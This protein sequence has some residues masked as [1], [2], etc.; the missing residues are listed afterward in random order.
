MF[1]PKSFDHLWFHVT[2]ATVCSVRYAM[3]NMIFQ[4]SMPFSES[5]TKG[6]H[7][8][9]LPYR[10]ESS[11]TCF[12]SK[13][14]PTRQ[15][16]LLVHFRL[17]LVSDPGRACLN[18]LNHVSPLFFL[19]QGAKVLIVVSCTLSFWNIFMWEPLE[20]AE[21]A[22]LSKCTDIDASSICSCHE[23]ALK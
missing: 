23:Q 4:D 6:T 1:W 16:V 10:A 21:P 15:A 12:P 7:V 5:A 19:R 3:K 14:I 20:L 17:T 11:Y 18:G 2:D 13:E 8:T 9:V 22:W